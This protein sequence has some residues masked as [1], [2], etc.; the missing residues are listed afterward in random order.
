MVSFSNIKDLLAIFTLV[1]STTATLPSPSETRSVWSVSLLVFS[2]GRHTES[3]FLPSQQHH[4][5]FTVELPAEIPKYARVQGNGTANCNLTWQGNVVP[6]T[7]HIRSTATPCGFDCVAGL[8][9]V[10]GV[11]LASLWFRIVTLDG[12][13]SLAVELLNLERLE[14]VTLVSSSDEWRAA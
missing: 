10:E 12:P 14:D 7:W 3:N 9:V 1:A 2:A 13:K 6:Q 8:D 4:L 5:N 11:Y